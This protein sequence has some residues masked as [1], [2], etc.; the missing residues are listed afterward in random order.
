M[1]YDAR[2]ASVCA[3]NPAELYEFRRGADYWRYTS[4]DED[5]AYNSQTYGKTPLTR[6]DVEELS[7]LNRI[8]L[9]ITLSRDNPVAEL[10]RLYPPGD[11][12]TVT[13]RRKHRDDAEA[14]VI[15]LGRVLNCEWAGAEAVLHS[16]PAYTSIRRN[17][18]R[19][20][21][22][23][24]CPHVLYG[25]ACGVNQAA[26]KISGA[27]SG[28]SGSTITVLAADA[29]ADGHFAGGFAAYASAGATENRLI[30]NH[31]GAV[32]TLAAPILGL[33]LG[34]AVDLYPGCD[35]TLSTCAAKFS[36]HLNYGGMPYI[37]EKNPFNLSTL[38]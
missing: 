7:E 17:A 12:V 29:L 37:P 31:A 22:Q 23:R 9:K 3:G 19:R 36:N 33:W 5:Q 13:I 16:E 15:W 6:S 34:D 26:F 27:V 1:T 38:Y 14:I 21:Y 24:Q 20:H 30:T 8:N 4:A 18:L 25:S 2:E 11:V 10:F 28:V 35:H 32:L